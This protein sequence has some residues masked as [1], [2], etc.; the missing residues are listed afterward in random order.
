MLNLG[1]P[2]TATYNLMA[3]GWYRHMH[4]SKHAQNKV[5]APDDDGN[6]NALVIHSYCLSRTKKFLTGMRWRK[7]SIPA[8]TKKSKKIVKTWMAGEKKSVNKINQFEPQHCWLH[9]QSSSYFLQQ[10]SESQA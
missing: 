5:I 9:Q 10:V 3:L 7:K 8:L 1:A 4:I 2:Q 6:V